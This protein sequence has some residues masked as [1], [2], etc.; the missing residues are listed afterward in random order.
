MK[1]KK[2]VKKPAAR[3]AS[4]DKSKAIKKT[5]KQLQEEEEERKRKE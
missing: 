4:V 5:K 1:V 2:E 3:G